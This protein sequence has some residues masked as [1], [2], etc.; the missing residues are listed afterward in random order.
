MRENKNPREG[1]KWLAVMQGTYKNLIEHVEIE[2]SGS[3]RNR[4]E[5]VLRYQGICNQRETNLKQIMGRGGALFFSM[6]RVVLVVRQSI[7]HHIP[8]S[9]TALNVPTLASL[10]FHGTDLSHEGI[11]AVIQVI[12]HQKACQCFY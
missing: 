9:R 2:I 3:E 8:R 1:S 11:G 7:H 10:I 4:E 12:F 6:A 5:A